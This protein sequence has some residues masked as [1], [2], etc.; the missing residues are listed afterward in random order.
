MQKHP[1]THQTSFSKSYTLLFLCLFP[2]PSPWCFP[3]FPLRVP[4]PTPSFSLPFR[5][6]FPSSA[7]PL[8]FSFSLSTLFL[9]LSLFFPCFLVVC[10]KRMRH[11]A[12]V[13]VSLEFRGSHIR[14]SILQN[15]FL[16]L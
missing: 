4:L 15:T 8:L 14:P 13:N 12:A 2:F 16:L 10:G 3:S 5:F 1:A 11:R 9:S 7:P 6:H